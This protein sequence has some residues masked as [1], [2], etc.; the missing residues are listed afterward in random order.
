MA[1]LN[2]SQ[3]SSTRW[4]AIRVR[5]KFQSVASEVLLGKGYEMFLPYY[6]CVRRLSGRTKTLQQPLFP[7]YLFCRFDPTDRMVPI[8]T[9]PGVMG[10]VSAG[11]TPLPIDDEEIAGLQLMLRS[12]VEPEPWPYLNSG[13]KVLIERGPLTGLEAIVV[14][15]LNQWRVVVS[16]ELLQRSVAAEIDREW[17]REVR[18]NVAPRAV[19]AFAEC[20]AE[21]ASANI[22]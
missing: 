13:T 12:G 18:T 20:R 22:Y 2:F 16:V 11:R 4:Y 7:G 9:T 1:F 14:Q 5:S 17:V 3:N 8:V 19:T 6:N 10:I 15:N 21:Y